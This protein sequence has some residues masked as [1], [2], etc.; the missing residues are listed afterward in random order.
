MHHHLKTT[1]MRRQDL[2]SNQAGP[3]ENVPFA[4][5]SVQSALGG[6]F[7]LAT[8]D[9]SSDAALPVAASRW[10]CSWFFQQS[11]SFSTF[12]KKKPKWHHGKK[13]GDESNCWFYPFLVA[14]SFSDC[15][16]WISSQLFCRSHQWSLASPPTSPL[17]SLSLSHTCSQTPLHIPLNWILQMEN[18]S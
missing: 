14:M 9:P 7:K 8:T 1:K 5:T 13:K 6:R 18:G 2:R 12:K 11:V 15:S 16:Q 17:E 3:V 4:L 10:K